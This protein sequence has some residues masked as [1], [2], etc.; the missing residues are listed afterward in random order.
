MSTITRDEGSVTITTADNIVVVGLRNPGRLNAFT[1]NMYDHL[2]A[3]PEYLITQDDVR[4]VVI[5]GEG[6]TAFA[7][8][9]D[10]NQFTAFAT[11]EHGVAYEHRVGAVFEALTNI[12]VPTIALVEGPA[13]GA[14][15]A[16]AAACDI[17]LATPE[18]VFGA[19]IAR[20]LGNC[21]PAPVIARLQKRLGINRTM[22]ILLTATMLSAEDAQT[23][24]FVHQVY[25]ADAIDGELRRLLKRISTSAPLT[26]ASIK[27]ISRRIERAT[28]DVPSDDLLHL[29]YGSADFQE[30]VRA[31]LEHRH[32]VWKGQ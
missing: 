17:V 18:S 30:G 14:G 9:T 5:R 29:C 21:M 31:F 7:A 22:A 4:A 26:L 8:G 15:L 6:G 25:P 20:T 10:I 23:A 19:P 32:P 28:P 3:L 12:K 2:A 24:G 16:V 13:V 1:W 27:E 11:G